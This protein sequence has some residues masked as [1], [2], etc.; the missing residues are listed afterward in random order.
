MK[1]LKIRILCSL[2]IA[3]SFTCFVYLNTRKEL[4]RDTYKSEY[5]TLNSKS[6]DLDKDEEPSYHILRTGIV[7][8]LKAIVLSD[9]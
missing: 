1:Q 7:L 8:I 4:S 3:I 6:P 5:V 9:K 2:L